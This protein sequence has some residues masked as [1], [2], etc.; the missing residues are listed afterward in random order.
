MKT[1]TPDIHVGTQVQPPVPAGGWRVDPLRS[2][3]SFSARVAGRPVRGRL[4]LTGGALISTSI[5]DSQARLVAS[6]SAL[7][8]GIALLDRLLLGPGFLDAEV[9][10]EI[11]FR[12]EMLVSV[13]T[14]WRAIGQLEVKG[15]EHAMACELAVNPRDPRTITSRWVLDSKWVTNQRV[16]ALSRNIAMTCSVAL[17]PAA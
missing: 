12:S 9:F 4:P 11:S 3:A 6:T 10:P 13:P 16:L 1:A 5:E 2:S 17:E 14:G 7:S 8:T 15:K